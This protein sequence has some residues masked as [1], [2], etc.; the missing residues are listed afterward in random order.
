MKILCFDIGGT[1]IKYS[2]IE[3]IKNYD[4]LETKTRKTKETN[5]I[6]QDVIKIIEKHKNIDAVGI[7]T[8][9]VVDSKK[10]EVIFAGPTIP[11]YTGTKFKEIIEKTYNIPCFV[12]NDVN[13][14]AYG[15]YSYS[16]IDGL[17]FCLTLGTGVGGSIIYN[18][19]LITGNSMTAGEIGYMP[20]KR[21]YFQDYASTSFLVKKASKK[22]KRQVDGY[23]IFEEAKNGNEIC[24]ELIDEMVN[25]LSKGILN[26]IYLLNPKQ[27]IIGGAITK[28]GN[29][30]K[31]KIKKSVDEKLVSDSFKTDIEFAKLEN[32]AG[33]YGIYHRVLNEIKK[34]G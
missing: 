14:A 29:Y 23:T 28:Q 31:N 32:G 2:L 34:E 22:L 6:L 19:N 3:D 10:G 13:S 18:G 5:Y 16:N 15:E 21:G 17:I 8:A 30:L 11:D 27:I 20:Y 12:E 24:I 9:G 25:N 33:I 4:I 26:I 7:S 1:S